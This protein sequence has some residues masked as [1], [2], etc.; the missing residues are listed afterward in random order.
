MGGDI[1]RG[2][3]PLIFIDSWLLRQVPNY[4]SHYPPEARL[5]TSDPKDWTSTGWSLTVVGMNNWRQFIWENQPLVKQVS[6]REW[7][8]PA[9]THWELPIRWLKFENPRLSPSHTLWLKSMF[10]M[11]MEPRSIRAPSLTTMTMDG[12]PSTQRS[13][14]SSWCGK[15]ILSPR[16]VVD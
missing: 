6:F 12:C 10:P 2:G 5:P 14:S 1:I 11:L 15:I 4:E 16:L 13:A 8:T 9:W 3:D 7:L